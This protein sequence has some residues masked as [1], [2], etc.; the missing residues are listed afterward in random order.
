MS[1]NVNS[2]S[3]RHESPRPRKAE[4]LLE[5]PLNAMTFTEESAPMRLGDAMGYF[6]PC[7]P[8]AFRVSEG[9]HNP[10]GSEGVAKGEEYFAA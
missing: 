2:S 4:Q 9:V 10:K 1:K 8:K 7:L 3:P 5:E 6:S